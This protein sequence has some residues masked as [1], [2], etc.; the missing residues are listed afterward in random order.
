M[1]RNYFKI[2]WRNLKTNKASSAIS[3]GGLAVGMTVAILIGLWLWDELSY[4]KSFTNYGRIVQ[5]ME[6]QTTNGIVHSNTSIPFPLGNELRT[7]YGNDFKYV[8]MSSWP[9]D[10]IL[11]SGD[12]ILSQPGIYMDADALVCSS[13]KCLKGVRMGLKNRIR[14]YSRPLRQKQ[15]LLMSTPWIS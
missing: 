14:F 1:F 2:A 3:I 9:R 6:H 13:S 12:K 15:C 4:N 10:H 11:S 8:V 7:V 5:V